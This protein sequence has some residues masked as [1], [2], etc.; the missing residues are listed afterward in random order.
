MDHEENWRNVFNH[1]G[2]IEKNYRRRKTN[3]FSYI[4]D[5]EGDIKVNNY[6]LIDK[7]CE[8]TTLQSDIIRKQANVIE[9]H[10]IIDSFVEESELMN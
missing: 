10:K 9:Q 3:N 1:N 6:E 8:I 2:Y 4:T 5:L 7:L